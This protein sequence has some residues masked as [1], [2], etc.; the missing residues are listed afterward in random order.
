[1][2]HVNQSETGIKRELHFCNSL[3]PLVIRLGFEHYIFIANNQLLIL[4]FII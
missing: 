1:M 3:S 4:S 2:E